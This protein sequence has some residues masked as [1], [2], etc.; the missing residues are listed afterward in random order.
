MSTCRETQDIIY[1][2]KTNQWKS[3]WHWIKNFNK[4]TFQ[5]T[6]MRFPCMIL[7]H[8][9]SIKDFWVDGGYA[10]YTCDRCHKYIQ[11]YEPQ[12]DGL[13]IND[14][15]M[16]KW[17]EEITNKKVSY[18]LKD[19]HIKIFWEQFGFDGEN[20]SETRKNET[21]K[22]GISD[23]LKWRLIEFYYGGDK[24]IVYVRY[25]DDPNIDKYESEYRAEKEKELHEHYQKMN[26][27][28]NIITKH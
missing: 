11:N 22:R 15:K 19:N 14:T 3:V 4:L 18:K 27:L 17:I 16:V 26:I 8:K 7:G 12:L 23:Y 25:E 6:F 20:N 10:S 5:D 9:Y 2:I 1:Y 21:I 13:S 28:K 24:Q